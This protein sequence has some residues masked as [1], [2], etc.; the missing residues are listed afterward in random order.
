MSTRLRPCHHG[1]KFTVEPPV[2]AFGAHSQE[3]YAL[4]PLPSIWAWT[5][6]QAATHCAGV[7]GEDPQLPVSPADQGYWPE[8]LNSW[9]QV[10]ITGRASCPTARPMSASQVAQEVS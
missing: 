8:T 5:A 10:K 9:P 6:F 3:A 7:H 4:A 2:S 1:V